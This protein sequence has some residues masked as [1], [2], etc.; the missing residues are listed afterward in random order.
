MKSSTSEAIAAISAII[1][2]HAVIGY[3]LFTVYNIEVPKS[4]TE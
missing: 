3:F 4:R 2:A 1:T